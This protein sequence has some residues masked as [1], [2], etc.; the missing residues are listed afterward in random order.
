M[1]VGRRSDWKRN[2][3]KIRAE[4]ASVARPMGFLIIGSVLYRYLERRGAVIAYLTCLYCKI[5]FTT[6]LRLIDMHRHCV[7]IIP[8]PPGL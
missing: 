4:Q 5:R 3:R 2:R 6:I 8:F 1:T 7:L